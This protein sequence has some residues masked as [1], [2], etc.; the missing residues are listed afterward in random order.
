MKPEEINDRPETAPSKR[1]IKY[2]SSYQN[3]LHGCLVALDVGLDTM[4]A[5]CP[6]FAQWLKKLEQLKLLAS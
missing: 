2:F 6:H 4:R 5:R 1:I 3:P